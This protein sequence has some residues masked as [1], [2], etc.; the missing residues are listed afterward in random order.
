MDTSHE[1]PQGDGELADED[2]FAALQEG[3]ED[4]AAETGDPEEVTTAVEDPLLPPEA[5]RMPCAL[6]FVPRLDLR[7][8][9]YQVEAVNA[10]LGAGGRGIVVLPTGAGK[11]IVAYSAMARLGVRTLVVV[12]TIE[13]LRQWRAGAGPQPGGPGGGGGRVRGRGRAGGSFH[14]ITH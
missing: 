3:E 13:L 4:E 7:P 8:R 11:T 5:V 14:R 12:P 6:P 10:W 2:V 9:L 1:L